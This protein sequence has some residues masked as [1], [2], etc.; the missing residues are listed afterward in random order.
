[1]SLHLVAQFVLVY[2]LDRGGCADGHEYGRFDRPAVGVDDARPGPRLRVGVKQLKSQSIRHEGRKVNRHTEI[3]PN[4]SFS[5]P[6][7]LI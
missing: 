2:G 1:L 3:G 4:L 7:E 6:F 5:L